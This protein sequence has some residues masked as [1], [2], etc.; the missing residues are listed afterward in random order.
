MLAIDPVKGFTF[1]RGSQSR[2]VLPRSALLERI[3]DR[4]D[5]GEKIVFTNGCFDLLHI[6]HL[7]YLQDAAR[8]GDCLIVA[9]NSDASVALQGK[10]KEGERPFFGE[11]CRA[12]ML[13]ALECV[14]FVTIHSEETPRELLAELKPD[15]LVKGGDYRK[16][17]IVGWEIVEGYGGLVKPLSFVPKCSTTKLVE[18]IRQGFSPA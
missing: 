4:R 5:R 7:T 6:G 18:L 13:A 3:E 11:E 12:E 17:E 2:K 1:L 15:V 16:N 9:I 10:G 8:E 14:D